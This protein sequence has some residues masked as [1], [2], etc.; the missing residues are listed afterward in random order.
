LPML[1]QIPNILTFGRLVLTVIFLAILLYSQGVSQENYTIILDVAL[2]L[3]II[4]GLTDIIDGKVARKFNVTS[5]M[6]RMMDPLADKILVCGTFIVFAVI[7][8]PRLFVPAGSQS[9]LLSWIHWLIAGILLTRELYVTII[10][11]LAEAR[12]I[13]FAATFSGKT[14]MFLQS[15]AI[16][17]VLIKAAHVPK[18]I[19]GDW[20]VSVIFA[21]MIIA[22]VVS[23][24]RATRRTKQNAQPSA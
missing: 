17:A 7:G 13:N 22:T 6:G 16:V 3:F 1:R 23:G 2:A 11:H 12:G 14:K 9:G 20:V 21:L 4:A 24:L 19:W 5:K 15:A 8:L 18:A 10:R